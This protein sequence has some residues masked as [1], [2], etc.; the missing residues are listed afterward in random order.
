M[1]I[2][3][4]LGHSPAA[5]ALRQQFSR[6]DDAGRR[7][8]LSGQLPDGTLSTA[9]LAATAG[10][11]AALST[12]RTAALRLLEAGKSIESLGDRRPGIQLRDLDCFE[13]A[14]EKP[15]GLPSL[16]TDHAHPTGSG[17]FPP[18]QDRF[19]AAL[20]I[21]PP[22]VLQ[23]PPSNLLAVSSGFKDRLEDL[24]LMGPDGAH[25][26]WHDIEGS[27]P[28][29]GS[30]FLAF[31]RAVIHELS[32]DPTDPVTNELARATARGPD[33][34]LVS[35]LSLDTSNA[36]ERAFLNR[37]LQ[38]DGQP[39][40][41]D[42][43]PG[44]MAQALERLSLPADDPR[45]I[46]LASQFASGEKF[47]QFLRDNVHALHGVLAPGGDDI[48]LVSPSGNMANTNF[49]K[50]HGW[51]DEVWTSYLATPGGQ[52]FQSEVDP[53]TGLS[54]YQQAM[55][56]AHAFLDNPDAFTVGSGQQ[57]TPPMDHS[58]H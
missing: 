35:P 57:T 43:V 49:W 27:L 4:T 30:H 13:S 19:D 8:G 56:D 26:K 45:F 25:R 48:A 21:S 9:D 16:G 37:P 55:N 29:P 5:L 51:I 47:G 44:T 6:I 46:E 40:L 53:A 33:G 24:G 31:H 12:T 34:S 3:K 15:A 11:V 7:S 42:G 2:K 23:P 20:P 32:G 22:V 1:T 10:D 41:V 39:V 54:P 28:N 14:H 36:R 50:M 17:Y 52:A 18:Y 58:M 38:L